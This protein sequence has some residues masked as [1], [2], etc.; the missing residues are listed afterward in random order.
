MTPQSRAVLCE[1][2]RSKCAKGI[3]PPH[4]SIANGWHLGINMGSLLPKL[5]TM[6]LYAIRLVRLFRNVV[7]VVGAS[8]TV[9]V[10]GHVIAL[11]NEACIDVEHGETLESLNPVKASNGNSILPFLNEVDVSIVFI[12][13]YDFWNKIISVDPVTNRP[14]L[15]H[16]FRRIFNIDFNSIVLWLQ[17]LKVFSYEYKDAVINDTLQSKVT[18]EENINTILQSARIADSEDVLDVHKMSSLNHPLRY[19]PPAPP[20]H[21]DGGCPDKKTPIYYDNVTFYLSWDLMDCIHRTGAPFYFNWDL[22]RCA[23]EAVNHCLL[24]TYLK[25][26]TE[27]K[28]IFD[29]QYPAISEVFKKIM[30][31]KLDSYSGKQHLW[32]L[33]FGVNN[34]DFH[35]NGFTYTDVTYC[36]M[37][38]VLQ[39]EKNIDD[40][41]K[42]CIY[43]RSDST[44]KHCD[45][46][47][48]T[49]TNTLLSVIT[50]VEAFNLYVPVNQ[51]PFEI[52][53][54][55][56]QTLID[57]Q[58]TSQILHGHP[59]DTC[60]TCH[61]TCT[62]VRTCHTHPVILN[63]CIGEQYFTPYQMERL[64][65][66]QILYFDNVSYSL[67]SVIYGNGSHFITRFIFDG[68]AYQGDGLRKQHIMGTFYQR[69][70]CIELPN[71]IHDKP[72]PGKIPMTNYHISHA[73][74]IRTDYIG[75]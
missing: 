23:W 65:I 25:I 37:H 27:A 10:T 40:C 53:S 50:E 34:I 4:Y 74:Y 1:E 16:A 69:S 62:I 6:E 19:V 72:F 64:V 18:L 56:L 43:S 28:V 11:S 22:N 8:A 21:P 63:V 20:E 73:H 54:H 14:R 58:W 2:C 26:N 13:K 45:N 51:T 12:G 47:N 71:S 3:E 48:C 30:L 42:Q 24:V 41:N 9:A 68:R 35:N 49:A 46:I 33:W 57:S 59:V 67:S 39:K 60:S 52:E 75:V 38:E 61:S 17:L 5:S 66:N 15:V 31:G 44:S 36:Y 32:M 7:K 55:H 70:D 29:R